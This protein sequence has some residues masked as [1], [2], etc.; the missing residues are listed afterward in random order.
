MKRMVTALC[1]MLLLSLAGC[2]KKDCVH[3]WTPATCDQPVTCALCGEVMG[4]A[5]GHSWKAADCEYAETCM[6]CKATRGEAL[7]HTWQAATCT[8]AAVCTVCNA[9]GEAALGHTFSAPNYQAP[10]CCLVCGHSE[11]QALTPKFEAYPVAVILPQMGQE[12]SYETSCYTPGYTTTGTLWWE[13]YRVFDGDETHQAVE[14]YQ[15]HTVTLK[16]T[17]SDRNAYKFGFI[18][19]PALDDYYWY[20]AETE[21]GYDDAFIV[22]FNGILYDQCLRANTQAT[23]SKWENNTCTYTA[24]YAWRVPVGYD[25]HLILLLPA[26]ADASQL[27]ESGDESILV[28]KFA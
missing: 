24:T 1:L 19:Q 14:G 2:G 27:L 20:A 15:W 22:N 8:D 5:A 3:Q 28:F 7:G 9:I 11:G 6:D 26:G 16:I 25:G 10:S 21:N 18:V 4:E 13:D 12:F 17:F 23:L